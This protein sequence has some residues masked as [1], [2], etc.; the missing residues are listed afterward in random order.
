MDDDT[1]NKAQARLKRISGQVTG[2]QRMVDDDRHCV[3]ILLQ[4]AAAQA[5]LM[6][7]GR[8]ILAGHFEDCLT[9]AMKS[10]DERERRKKLDELVNLFSRFCHWEDHPQ[11]DQGRA[12]PAPSSK[13]KARGR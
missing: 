1:K 9:E 13:P 4:V 12:S 3:D 5:A 7:A 11:D 2:I 10:R 6:V 8:V